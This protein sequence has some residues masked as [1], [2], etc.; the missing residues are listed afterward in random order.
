MA[1]VEQRIEALRAEIVHH[2][3]R[4]YD[5]DDPEISDADY[6]QLIGELRAL[7]AEHPELVT[8]DSPT[9]IIGGSASELFAPVEHAVPMMS[10]D[11]AFDLDELVAWGE[12]LERRAEGEVGPYVCEL[13]IDG[14]AISIRY[15]DG[16]L[17][18]A[19]T[20]GDGRTG[21]DVTANIATLDGVPHR[22]GSDAPAV[23][24]VRGEVYL[25]IA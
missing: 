20:R 12:R 9:Q 22:L 4:Y 15:L 23:L 21:E 1:D 2:N 3:E 24:E 17:T 6:D 11:N 5:R 18:Q 14:V 16:E 10:L 7:E 19:A 13:K 25:P 8:E